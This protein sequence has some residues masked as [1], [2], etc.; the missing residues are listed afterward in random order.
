M[1]E[2]EI[3]L[4]LL[5]NM[6]ELVLKS[7]AKINLGLQVLG[8]RSDGYHEVRTI[9]QEIELHDLLYL[10]RIEEGIQLQC[11]HPR[12]PLN[13]QNLAFKA[14]RLIKEKT[15]FS[16]GV[17]IYLDKKIPIGGGLGGGSSN[18]A[19]VIKGLNQLWG[20]G[21]TREEM[22]NLGAEIGSDVP[23]FI[24]G[25]TALATG[26]GE[27]IQQL[28]SFP[29]TWLIVITPDV[30]IS[31]SWAY[32]NLNLELT[33]CSTNSNVILPED[34]RNRWFSR[35]WEG[36]W[37]NAFEDLVIR[38]YPVVGEA[39]KLLE[40]IG[41]RWVSLSGSGSSVFGI[42][43]NQGEAELARSQITES[44][45]FVYLTHTVER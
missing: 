23:F 33:N 24:S 30:E 28:P 41:A 7:P 44:T 6:K 9:L 36:K 31:T 27:K 2:L 40:Q 5:S 45:W 26:R 37:I 13:E 17:K 22:Q 16:G 4:N 10:S 19:C 1:T 11:N 25:G 39:K 3:I 32:K 14:A 35:V 43:N 18:A 20:L 38:E 12:L 8:K 15:R 42:F 29:K 34:E 21:L